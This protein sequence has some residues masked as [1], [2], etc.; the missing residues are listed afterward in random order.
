[1]IKIKHCR[2]EFKGAASEIAADITSGVLAIA[3]FIS[4]KSNSSV[5]ETIDSIA[6]IA[7]ET[8]STMKEEDYKE[9]VK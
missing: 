2:T 3:I 6:R 7:K 8:Y 4:R 5:E 9:V 1:M